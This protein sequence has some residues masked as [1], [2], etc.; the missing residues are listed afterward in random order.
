MTFTCPS[1]WAVIVCKS[2]NRLWKHHVPA[3]STMFTALSTIASFSWSVPSWCRHCCQHFQHLQFVIQIMAQCDLTW[4]ACSAL[5]TT[6]IL[7]LI[8]LL[9]WIRYVSDTS[10]SAWPVTPRASVQLYSSGAVALLQKA[11]HPGKCSST[12]LIAKEQVLQSSLQG[13]IV[14]S[15]RP[16]SVQLHRV[17]YNY[18][19]S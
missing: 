11:C 3:T 6:L 2:I 12:S 5:D 7:V 4:L 19:H 10:G 9:C 13:R 1:S 18:K 17:I 16:S 15:G 14:F 8:D